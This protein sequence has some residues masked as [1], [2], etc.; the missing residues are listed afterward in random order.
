M[1]YRTQFFGK[2]IWGESSRSPHPGPTNTPSEALS[3]PPEGVMQRRPLVQCVFSAKQGA[4]WQ[5]GARNG[6]KAPKRPA[7]Q[8]APVHSSDEED[9]LGELRALIAR[10]ETLEKEQ[11]L[12]D[13][14][15]GNGGNT[16]STT[17]PP[18]RSPRMGKGE[19]LRQ[20][21]SSRTSS[22][23]GSEVPVRPN[24]GTSQRVDDAQAA[25]HHLH[26]LLLVRQRE[27]SRWQVRPF[28]GTANSG[29][30]CGIPRRESQC[31]RSPHFR[32]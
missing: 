18:Q 19:R 11:T 31:Q 14:G 1:G 13:A 6:D 26:H 17:P 4:Q 16:S 25:H 12:C 23:E 10:V 5:S 2:I 28:L 30:E 22:L 7:S 27:P 9:Y 32:P 20:Y 21:L 29:P 15:L 3:L 24:P 8:P